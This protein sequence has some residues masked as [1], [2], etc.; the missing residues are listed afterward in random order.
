[1]WLE[2]KQEYDRINPVMVMFLN[3]CQ[4]AAAEIATPVGPGDE[5]DIVPALEGG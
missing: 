3:N 5:I 1:M 2:R 4:L